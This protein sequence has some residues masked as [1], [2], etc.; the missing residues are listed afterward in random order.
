MEQKLIA[1]VAAALGVPTSVLELETAPGDVEAW[2]S[3]AHINVISEVE[4][5]FG[6][7][8]PIE[9]IADIHC[10]GDFLVYLGKKA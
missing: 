8:I 1:V 9:K 10:I 4:A 5:E 2:D 6:V 7:S 3:L